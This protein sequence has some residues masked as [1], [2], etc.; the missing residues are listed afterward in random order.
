MNESSEWNESEALLSRIRENLGI[1]L[2]G[3]TGIDNFEWAS[4]RNLEF[5]LEFLRQAEDH[6]REICWRNWPYK[7][8][9]DFSSPPNID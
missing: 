7:D 1:D 8:D 2:E 5:R 9:T 6:Q 4:Q 3:G